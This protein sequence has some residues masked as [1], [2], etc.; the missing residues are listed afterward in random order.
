MAEHFTSVIS[1]AQILVGFFVGQ[2]AEEEE[3][4][5]ERKGLFPCHRTL[6]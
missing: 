6:Q 2:E 1:A 3:V 4:T 5:E